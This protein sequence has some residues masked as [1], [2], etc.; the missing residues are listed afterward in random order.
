MQRAISTSRRS[1]ALSDSADALRLAAQADIVERFGDEIAAR[2]AAGRKI[3][4]RSGDVVPD[5]QIFDHLLGL[6]GAAHA[7]GRAPVHGDAQQIHAV[8]DRPCRPRI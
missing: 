4:E 1:L 5:R 7:K 8:D 3:V 2:A 6:K